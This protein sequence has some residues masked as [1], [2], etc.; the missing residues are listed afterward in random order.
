MTLTKQDWIESIHAQEQIEGVYMQIGDL[1]AEKEEATLEDA[2]DA[3]HETLEE[4][5]E[6]IDGWIGVLEDECK[7]LRKSIIPTDEVGDYYGEP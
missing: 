6:Y 7:E 5:L 1:E 3:G 2:Q 4:Y